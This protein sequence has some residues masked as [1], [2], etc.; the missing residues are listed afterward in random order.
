MESLKP[1]NVYPCLLISQPGVHFSRLIFSGLF[2]RSARIDRRTEGAVEGQR[3]QQLKI[4][5]VPLSF[6]CHPCAWP[7]KVVF[8]AFLLLPQRHLAG[9]A[10]GVAPSC[11]AEATGA[12]LVGPT[13]IKSNP[14]GVWT[15]SRRTFLVIFGAPTGDSSGRWLL[16]CLFTF[17]GF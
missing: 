1:I 15:T 7:V 9:E 10:G 11:T 2:F 3:T 16:F 12:L 5:E 17:E 6:S 13:L 14:L 4:T 8:G